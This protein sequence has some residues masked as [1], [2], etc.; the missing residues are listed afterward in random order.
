MTKDM[1]N[2][3]IY[4]YKSLMIH[5]EDITNINKYVNKSQIINFQG[6]NKYHQICLQILTMHLHS[7]DM[8]LESIPVRGW[9]TF[10]L[11]IKDPQIKVEGDEEIFHC[12]SSKYL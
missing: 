12:L 7:K 3:N 1:T 8:F 10:N 6:N 9:R 2:I 11:W 5:S 4:V